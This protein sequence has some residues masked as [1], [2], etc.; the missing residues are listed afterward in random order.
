VFIS[1][2]SSRRNLTVEILRGEFAK[3]RELSNRVEEKGSYGLK[4]FHQDSQGREWRS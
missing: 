1:Q 3:F 2:K 4:Y